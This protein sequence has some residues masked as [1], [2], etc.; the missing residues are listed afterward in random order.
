M[1]DSVGRQQNANV[2]NMTSNVARKRKNKLPY[3]AA[4][5]FY[6]IKGAYKSFNLI[7]GAKIIPGQTNGSCYPITLPEVDDDNEPQQWAS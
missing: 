2:S 4:K 3:N 7:K 6:S 5:I 1:C